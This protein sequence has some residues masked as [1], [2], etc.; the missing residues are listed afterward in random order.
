MDNTSLFKLSYGLYLLTANDSM[1]DN[2]CIINTAMQVTSNAP[3]QGIITVNKANFTHDLIMNSKKFN[4]STLTTDAPF[5]VFEHFGFNSGKNT[6]KF[7]NF[8]DVARSENGVLYLTKYANAYMSFEVTDAIDFDTHTMFK[9]TIS[10]GVVLS[11]VDSVTYTY[12]QQHIKPKPQ[13]VQ[14][15]GYRCNICVYIYEGDELPVDFVCPICK[16]GSADFTK[17]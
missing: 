8:S 13:P 12:Y 17:I 2:G 14:K 4:V 10:D 11:S 1:R 15:T 9:S 16:H 7:S 5:S 3:F 6:D